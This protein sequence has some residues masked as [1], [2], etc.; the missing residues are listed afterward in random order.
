VWFRRAVELNPENL[1]ALIN[2]EY[3]ELCQQGDKRRLEGEAL[4]KQFQDFSGKYDNW[5]EMLHVNGPVDEPTV[6][7]KIARALLAGRNYQQAAREFARCAEL[8][9]D[10]PEP[11]VWQGL[12]YIDLQ[13]YGTALD[14]ADRIQRM[15]PP[16]DEAG[17]AELLL[18]RTTALRGL[19]R[20]NEAAACI[21][22][23]VRGYH[24]RGEVLSKAADIFAQNSHFEGALT[25]LDGQL[26]S[27]SDNLKLLTKKGWAE[28]ELSRYDAAIATL[29][30]VVSSAPWDENARLNLAIA[31]LGAGQLD[32]AR[33]EYQ[34][35]LQTGAKSGNA[36]FGLGGISWRK[37]ETNTAI[38]FYEQY[39]AKGS[40]GSPQYQVA[41]ERLKQLQGERSQAEKTTDGK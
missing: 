14:L 38:G 18:C 15:S 25:L 28:L 6:L 30:R 35:L 16:Q 29:S 34:A 5:L 2:L 19:G 41:S 12:S 13:E 10:W 39:L 26:K 17:L 23:F 9:P 33:A 24:G 3:N 4:Q 36:L 27:E 22:S 21:E 32:E 7:F 37:H 20:T 11:K 31:H 1:A 8:A 40:P